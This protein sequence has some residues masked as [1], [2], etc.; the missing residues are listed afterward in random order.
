[1]IWWVDNDLTVLVFKKRMS[2]KTGRVTLLILL[3]IFVAWCGRWIYYTLYELLDFQL[4]LYAYLINMQEQ[5]G[6]VKTMAQ[7]SWNSLLDFVGAENNEKTEQ[8]GVTMPSSEERLQAATRKLRLICWVIS[9]LCSV[10]LRKV[11]FDILWGVKGMFMR[12]QRFVLE[13]SSI[14]NK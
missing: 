14:E 11:C 13:D 9:V 10:F 6:Q 3:T 1:M 8:L 4:T 12:I 2:W 5:Y 7:S